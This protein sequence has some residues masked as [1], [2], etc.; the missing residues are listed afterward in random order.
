MAEAYHVL[1]DADKRRDY[2]EGKEIKVKRGRG[3]NSDDDDEDDDDEDEDEEHK[4]TLREEVERE[5]YPERYQFWPFG[6]PFIY[7]RTRESQKRAREG[8]PSWFEEY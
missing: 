6:D 2:D 1:S 5:Y 3:M 8:K 7:K 4:T